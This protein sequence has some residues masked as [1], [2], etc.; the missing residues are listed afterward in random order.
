MSNLVT[1]SDTNNSKEEPHFTKLRKHIHNTV[2]LSGKLE[3]SRN[4]IYVSYGPCC[5]GFWESKYLA[6]DY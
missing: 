3:F 6:E 1:I 2:P 5:K 4:A